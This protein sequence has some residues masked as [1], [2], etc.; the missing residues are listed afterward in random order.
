MRVS[1][2]SRDTV[3]TAAVNSTQNSGTLTATST[4]AHRASRPTRE[5]RAPAFMR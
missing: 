4:A 5:R 2:T 3:S 1:T